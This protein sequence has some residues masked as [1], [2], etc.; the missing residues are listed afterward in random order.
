[1][2]SFLPRRLIWSPDGSCI[3]CNSFENDVL[4][5][6][7]E[8]DNLPLKFPNS[9]AA[10][11]WYPL[12]NISEKAS[13]AFATAVPFYPVQLVDSVDGHVRA[14][15]KC[16]SG[17]DQLAAVCSL[18]FHG[19]AILA[20]ST[21]CLFECDITRPDRAATVAMNCHGSILTMKE[22]ES[23]LVMGLSTGGIAFVD[24]RNY[25]CAFELSFHSHAVDAID[26]NGYMMLSSAKLE[27][28]VY[29]VDLRQPSVPLVRFET[30][31]QSSRYVS[32]SSTTEY[33]A[34]GSEAG[35]AIVYNTSGD[36]IGSIGSGPTPLAVFERNSSQ[37]VYA[38]GEFELI[39]D[40]E[41]EDV[42]YGPHL[43]EF[44][45]LTSDQICS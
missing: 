38:S 34:L 6:N 18:A 24:P 1:M 36:A 2:I 29:G 41:E 43:R 26:I 4:V 28:D 5:Y 27:S 12:M 31:R 13:C 44:A 20:G 16:V 42:E 9:V 15:Y 39:T 3:L 19:S 14:S 40:E 45:I 32:V 25:E 10:C 37:I 17:G 35:P 22:S 8:G 7:I 30:A 21:K 23:V 11:E 33:I